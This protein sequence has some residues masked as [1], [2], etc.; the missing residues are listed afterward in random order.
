MPF[1]SYETRV[2][3]LHFIPRLPFPCST[4]EGPAEPV[5]A[6]PALVP[7]SLPASSRQPSPSSLSGWAAARRWWQLI[8]KCHCQRLP[9]YLIWYSPAKLSSALWKQGKGSVSAAPAAALIAG[10]EHHVLEGSGS[11]CHVDAN[12]W[13]PQKERKKCFKKL[14]SCNTSFPEEMFNTSAGEA[15]HHPAKQLNSLQVSSCRRI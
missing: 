10:W 5:L 7:V 12:L 2:Q 6:A 15:C 1:A 14:F 9:F 4:P 13:S 11:L 3:S 8:M